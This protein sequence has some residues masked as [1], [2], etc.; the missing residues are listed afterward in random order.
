MTTEEIRTKLYN[1]AE[2]DYKVF[3]QKLLPGV[4][5][6]KVL[7]VRLPALRR[8]A[9]EIAKED[10]Q[11]Y[12]A[13]A[14]TEIGDDSL[15]EEIMLQGLV[16]GYVN[17]ERDEYR[18]YLDGFVPKITNW[19]V[20]DSCVNGFKFMRKDSDYWF[21]YLKSY[22]DSSR[23]FDIRFMIIAMMSHFIDDAHIEEI[24]NICNTIHNDG[25]YAKMGMAWTLQVCYVKYPGE[26]RAL[27]EKNDLDDFT[28]NKA[29]QKIRESRRV[30]RREKEELNR[31]KR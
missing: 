8:L 23:E 18:K 22:R 10:F 14:E 11:S 7:G 19:A 3:N 16:I 2:E 25:Y 29:I 15:H 9:R 6:D 1:L 28:H 26:T 13:E 24:L 17:A 30:S 21:D 27:L 12:L 20:C 31:L 5:E 4:D